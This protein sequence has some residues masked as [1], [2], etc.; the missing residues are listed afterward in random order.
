MSRRIFLV[1]P[2]G[3]GKT[4]V[5]AVLADRLGLK[6]IDADALIE[7]RAGRASASGFAGEGEAGVRE[8]EAA[9]LA[10]LCDWPDHV[11]AT[12]GGVVLRPENRERMS[13]AGVVVW[14]RADVDVLWARISADAGTAGRRPPL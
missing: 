6:W 1:G 2:R 13:A 10:E 14:L 8:R 5:A 4:T 9:L 7:E 3:S 12:G 11:I